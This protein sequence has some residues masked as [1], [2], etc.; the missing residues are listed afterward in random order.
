MVLEV[1]GRRKVTESFEIKMIFCKLA[2]QR[3]AGLNWVYSRLVGKANKSAKRGSIS[4]GN[5]PHSRFWR[6]FNLAS[7]SRFLLLYHVGTHVHVRVIQDQLPREFNDKL[8]PLLLL[9]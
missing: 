1:N 3:L 4:V 7:M 2:W 6:F 5:Y 9:R 8:S